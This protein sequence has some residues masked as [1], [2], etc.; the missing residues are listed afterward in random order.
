MGN[1]RTFMFKMN[2]EKFSVYFVFFDVEKIA[3]AM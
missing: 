1:L 3:L 2:T